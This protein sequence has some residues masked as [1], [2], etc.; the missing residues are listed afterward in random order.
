[1]CASPS[2]SSWKIYVHVQYDTEYLS[3]QRNEELRNSRRPDD[4]NYMPSLLLSLIL[5]FVQRDA[6]SKRVSFPPFKLSLMFLRRLARHVLSLGC[7]FRLVPARAGLISQKLGARTSQRRQLKSTSHN[8]RSSADGQ[9]AITSR[10]SN[11]EASWA[12]PLRHGL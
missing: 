2:S 6:Q 7:R 5:G 9:T 3:L 4:N 11:I 12:A 10:T 8:A 1:L